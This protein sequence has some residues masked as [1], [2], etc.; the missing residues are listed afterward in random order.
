MGFLGA[1]S[2]CRKRMGKKRF[3]ARAS[4]WESQETPGI[5]E[6]AASLH[7]TLYNGVVVSSMCCWID[8]S[9]PPVTLLNCSSGSLSNSLYKQ[10]PIQDYVFSFFGLSHSRLFYLTQILHNTSAGIQPGTF[11]PKNTVFCYCIPCILFI[12]GTTTKR[13]V[14]Y[15]PIT[16]SIIVLGLGLGQRQ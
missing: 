9:Q 2:Q 7:I 4:C 1:V 6:E 12:L 14:Q 10:A 3:A 16:F 11:T 15:D 8:H 5:V 13:Y